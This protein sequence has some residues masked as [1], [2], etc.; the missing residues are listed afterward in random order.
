MSYTDPSSPPAR[1]K[2]SLLQYAR[3]MGWILL[4][5]LLLQACNPTQLSQMASV[6]QKLPELQSENKDPVKKI[7]AIYALA[8]TEMEEENWRQAARDLE[9]VSRTAHTM[10]AQNM[11]AATGKKGAQRQKKLGRWATE[12]AYYLGHTY[13]MLGRT[14][15]AADE[16]RRALAWN[17]S[18]E[19]PKAAIRTQIQTIG[20]DIET[21]ATA[22]TKAEVDSARH[23]FDNDYDSAGRRTARYLALEDVESSFAI[24]DTLRGRGFIDFDFEEVRVAQVQAE[25]FDAFF[26]SAARANSL[27][28]VNREITLFATRSLKKYAMSKF[29]NAALKENIEELVGDQPPEEW[30]L[31][32]DIAVLKMAKAEK[33]IS[34][35]EK[36]YFGK[37]AG[38]LAAGAIGLAKGVDTV[39]ALLSQGPRLLSPEAL[40]G[41]HLQKIDDTREATQISM[42]NLKGARDKT[43]SLLE[44]MKVLQSAFSSLG[45]D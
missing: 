16:F 41:V 43:P 36:V 21:P 37:T 8:A 24:L 40:G 42:D 17:K 15:E 44:E 26:L 39:Q 29:A 33:K 28:D 7:E 23:R 3:L 22:L 12:S 34:R 1:T 5:G 31:E 32:E 35:D 2:H 11:S 38:A 19:I 25:E 18:P 30:T 10:Y 6:A 4:A 27:V 9:T 20:G 13:T 45:G 14:A